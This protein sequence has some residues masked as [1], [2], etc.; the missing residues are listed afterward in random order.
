M[1]P[2][3]TDSL[4]FSVNEKMNSVYDDVTL[5]E[6]EH[7]DSTVTVLATFSNPG[8][9]VILLNQSAHRMSRYLKQEC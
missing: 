9:Q 2:R 6:L 1:C 5:S 4:H 3:L 7:E 8:L